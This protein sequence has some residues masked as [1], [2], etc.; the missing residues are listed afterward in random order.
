[1]SIIFW[2]LGALFGL[3]IG[4]VFHRFIKLPRLFPSTCYSIGIYE[5]QS[6]LTLTPSHR[7]NNPVLTFNDV[8]DVPAKYIADPFMIYERDKWYMYFEV[9]N[10]KSNKGE[11]GL[12]TSDN[13]LAWS[14]QQ[15]ILDEPFHLSYPY[16][17]KNNN[18]FYMIPES[19]G[20]NYVRLYKAIEFPS[21]WSFEKN[22]IHYPLVDP[23]I[24]KYGNNWWI[25]ACDV[26]N[27]YN[28]HLYYSHDIYDPWLEHPKSPIVQGRERSRPGGRIITSHGKI[29]RYAQDNYPYYGRQLRAFHISKLTTE[30]YEENE[31][32]M[33]P[34]LKESG[35]GW[36]S[37]GMH[38]IDPHQL[39]EDRWIAC[40]DGLTQK[41][42]IGIK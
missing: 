39:A 13:G 17:F 6:P 28:L 24:F 27:K 37:I 26:V 8:T 16:V 7:I 23:S 41:W 19:M 34:V 4:K 30:D 20:A 40:V 31:I 15:I 14:Y 18:N 21:K 42:Q 38:N 3:Y 1:M 32:S 36:N 9:I 33:V 29:I 22:L 11:I 10:K 2:L 25:F 35:R 12:A 5:G